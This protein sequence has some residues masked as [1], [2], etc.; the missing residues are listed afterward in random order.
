MQ[1]N[2]ASP[3]GTGRFVNRF[4]GTADGH[5]RT[6]EGL[7]LSSIG[8]GTYLGNWDSDTDQAYIDSINRFIELGGN[9][10]DTASNYRFQR[11]ERN[12][13]EVVESLGGE[14]RDELFISTKAG[15]LPFDGEPVANVE[16]YFEAEF[17]SKGLAR[18]EDLVGGS[19]CMSSGYLD[20]Q[21]EQSLRN[22]KVD[23]I[24]LYYLHNPEAQLAEVDKYT[25]EARLAKAF[26]KLEEKRSEG[27]IS[28][29]GAATWD[30]FR[31]PP[32][33]EKYHS[34]ERFVGVAKQVAGDDHGFKFVQLP[35]NLAMPEAYVVP[36]QAA[37]GKA[38]P[39]IAAAGDLGVGVMV[40]ASL[41]QGQLTMNVPLPLRQSFSGLTDATTSLQFARSTPGVLSALVGMSSVAHVEENLSLRKVAP[42]G[43]SVYDE[44]FTIE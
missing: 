40:S 30:G 22:L 26:E 7:S 37:M 6:F 44:L 34:I 27:K 38:K 9:V 43:K 31:I 39:V 1:A 4:E 2:S 28:Y 15:Y 10:I 23:C 20:S 14:R 13:G 5:F 17:V 11:S 21:V 24:D 42:A 16:E 19:H 32:D 25:F 8:V 29:Y 33:Q 3:E 41:L 36:N 18:K 12:I 35:H